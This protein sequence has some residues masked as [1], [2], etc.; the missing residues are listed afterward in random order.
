MSRRRPG[1]RPSR[2]AAPTGEVVVYGTDWCSEVRRARRALDTAGVVHRYVDLDHDSAARALVRTVQRGGV[3]QAALSG[4]RAAPARGHH[5]RVALRQC[6]GRLP[7]WCRRAAMARTPVTATG[8]L[9]ITSAVMP[10][11]GLLLLTDTLDVLGASRSCPP[12]TVGQP[13]YGAATQEQA[14]SLRLYRTPRI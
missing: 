12:G 8:L 13:S 2:V 14:S 3:L 10:L 7:P 1:V 4:G 6:P 11:L 5:R 9:Q